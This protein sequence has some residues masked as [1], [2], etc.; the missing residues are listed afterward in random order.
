MAACQL[1]RQI[2]YG[3]QLRTMQMEHTKAGETVIWTHVAVSG[4]INCR[5]ICGEKVCECKT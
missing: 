3:V 1:E 5:K 2:N 4:F